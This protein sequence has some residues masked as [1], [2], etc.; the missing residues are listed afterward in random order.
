MVIAL[1]EVNTHRHPNGA[2]RRVAARLAAMH[3]SS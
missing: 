2:L 3:Q 1:G